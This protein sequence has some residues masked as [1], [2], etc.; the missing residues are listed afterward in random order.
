MRVPGRTG[1][2]STLSFA[3][4][5]TG[6]AASAQASEFI[7]QTDEIPGFLQGGL[8]VFPADGEGYIVEFAGDGTY[9]TGSGEVG[10]WI[11]QNGYLCLSAE[12]GSVSCT[13]VDP[14]AG[15]GD[16]WAVSSPARGTTRYALPGA[17]DIPDGEDS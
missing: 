8:A 15:P 12:S 14:D 16:Q 9:R 17:P 6:A 1:A 11:L 3:L 7:P 2:V 4:A 13:A 5:L 10:G